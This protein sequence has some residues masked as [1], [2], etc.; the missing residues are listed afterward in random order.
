[1][2]RRIATRSPG[3]RSTTGSKASTYPT[4]RRLPSMPPPR[5]RAAMRVGGLEARHVRFA[6]ALA[7]LLLVAACLFLPGRF[8]ARM[9]VLRDGRFTYRYAGEILFLTRHSAM[10]ADNARSQAFNPAYHP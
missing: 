1:M 8:E 7:A 2:S 4:P 5:I 9:T 10:D 3:C 6:A